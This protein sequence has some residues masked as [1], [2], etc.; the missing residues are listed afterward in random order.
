MSNRTLLEQ[1]AMS[2]ASWQPHLVGVFI[3]VV[4]VIASAVLGLKNITWFYFDQ[5]YSLVW[6]PLKLTVGRV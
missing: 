4:L 2:A 3:L 5:Q 6:I 1:A